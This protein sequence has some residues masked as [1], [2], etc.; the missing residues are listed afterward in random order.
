MIVLNASVTLAWC[1][2]EE[3]SPE[4]A[5]ILRALPDEGAW[6]PALWPIEVANS[7]RTSI[8]KGKASRELHAQY[9]EELAAL[10]I[11]ID[12]ETHTRAWSETLQLADTHDLTV[13]DASYLELAVRHR[14][15]LATL[16]RDLAKAARA[17]G[18]TV[19]P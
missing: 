10:P 12:S 17:E 3:R 11:E 14:L 4:V 18:L 1:F 8:R 19:L 5:G 6:V 16:D 13:Y 15:P 2:A 7:F 9:L